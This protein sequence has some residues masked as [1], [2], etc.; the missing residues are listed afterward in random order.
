MQLRIVER[1]RV[2]SA[3]A[4]C[5]P[6]SVCCVNMTTDTTMADHRL[7][8]SGRSCLKI[9][10]HFHIGLSA[11]VRGGTSIFGD[12]YKSVIMHVKLSL[13]SDARHDCTHR[14]CLAA[15]LGG[16]WWTLRFSDGYWG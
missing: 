8:I 11:V 12:L 10:K 7:R 4:A 14:W 15:I 3:G 5:A 9:G 16:W 13:V 1:L 6:S 2:A